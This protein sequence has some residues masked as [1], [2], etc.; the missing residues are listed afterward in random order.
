MSYFSPS[1][2]GGITNSAIIQPNGAVSSLFG[3]VTALAASGSATLLSRTVPP[4]ESDYLLRI[5]LSGSNIA[6]Y[7]VLI[8]GTQW[9]RARTWFGGPS[10]MASIMVGSTPADAFILN[11]GDVIQIN[12]TNVRPYSGDFEARLQY[13]EVS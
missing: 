6:T 5:E 4:G 10:L 1:G 11:P 13:I 12:V 7:D 3:Y 2:S 8:N 9:A